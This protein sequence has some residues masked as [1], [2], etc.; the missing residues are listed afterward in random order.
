M[1]LLYN[2]IYVYTHANTNL[3]VNIYTSTTCALTHRHTTSDTH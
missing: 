1:Q 2:K 3:Y